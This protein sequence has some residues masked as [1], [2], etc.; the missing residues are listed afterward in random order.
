MTSHPDE[1]RVVVVDDVPDCAESL[2]ALL[3]A[4]GYV[5]RISTRATEVPGVVR[6][7]D[8]HCVLMD[9]QMPGLDGRVLARALR[10]EHGSTIVLVACT[11]LGDASD[12]IGDDF[13]AFDHTLAKPVQPQ[14][15]RQLLPPL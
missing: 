5:V 15:L 10:A 3:A 9:V 11:G 1:V 13:A 6:E 4:D 14:Q 7:F 8:P 12:H 2:A